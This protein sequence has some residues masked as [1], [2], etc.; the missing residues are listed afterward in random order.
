MVDFSYYNPTRIEFGIGKEKDIGKQIAQFGVKKVLLCYGSERIKQNGLYDIVV[1]SLKS[2]GIAFITLGGIISNPTLSKV[3][4][5]IELAK[6]VD[7]VLSVG[8]GSVL[9]SA[10]AIAVGA[11]YEGDVW[12]FFVG[13][14]VIKDALLIFDILTLSATGSE[15]NGYS[16]ITNEITHQKYSISS[17]LIYPKVSIINPKLMESVSNEYLAYSAVDIIAHVIEGYFSATIQ[18]TFQSMLVESII[19]TVID[20][21]EILLENPTNY[22]ARAE[23]AWAS[24]LALNG[25]TTAGCKGVIF[26]NHI[27][28][29]SLSA[30]FNIAHGA[31]LAIVIPAWMKWY[32]EKNEAQFERFAKTIFNSNSTIEAIEDLTNWFKKINAPTKLS[33][34]GIKADSIKAIAQNASEFSKIY[35]TYSIYNEESIEEILKLAI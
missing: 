7:G 27:I 13:K 34:V 17:K 6:D 18:P 2:S 24:T 33:D 16:V 8:G 30:L 19:K 3:Y 11:T 9:D 35:G 21:T 31:G 5:G 26:A 4:E 14:S 29:H 32:H 1:E 12:D 25:L 20:T 28:E 15:M 22:S 10:K 23:F